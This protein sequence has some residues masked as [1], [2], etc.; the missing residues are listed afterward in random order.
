MERIMITV[1]PDLLAQVD[2][3]AQHLGQSRSRFVREALTVR[4]AA[5]ER[6]VFDALLAEG[7]RAMNDAAAEIVAELVPLQAMALTPW[8]WD[9]P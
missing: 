2:A 4:M 6:E 5:L 1:P 9:E 7:Y 3:A 8:T